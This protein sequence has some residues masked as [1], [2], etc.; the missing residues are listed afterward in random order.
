MFKNI[1]AKIK[2]FASFICYFGIALSV[3]LGIILLDNKNI[4]AA[5][6]VI[7]S[8]TLFS[9]L[10]SLFLYAFGQLVENSDILVEQNKEIIKLTKNEQL[11]DTK[12]EETDV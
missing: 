9:W 4:P 5:L 8:G 12:N 3:A 2:G 1:G 6:A 10:G 11:S 7:F